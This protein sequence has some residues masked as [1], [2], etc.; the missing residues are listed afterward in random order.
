MSTEAPAAPSAPRSDLKTDRRTLIWLGVGLVI[1]LFSPPLLAATVAGGALGE[2]AGTFARKRML[3]GIEAKMDKALPAGSA[4]GIA[5]YDHHDAD[6]VAK[7][8]SNAIRTSTVQID[9]ASAQELK[10]GLE[11]ASAGLAG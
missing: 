7:A 10:A 5:I 4:A 8:L 9:K 2:L 6:A 11:K 3:A 1:G